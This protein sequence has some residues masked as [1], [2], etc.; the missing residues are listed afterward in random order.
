MMSPNDP[1]CSDGTTPHTSVACEAPRIDLHKQVVLPII[2]GPNSPLWMLTQEPELNG[3]VLNLCQQL[4]EIRKSPNTPKIIEFSRSQVLAARAAFAAMILRGERKLHRLCDL[5]C[6][7]LFSAYQMQSVVFGQIDATGERFVLTQSLQR[8]ELDAISDLDLGTRQ[9]RRIA[10]NTPNGTNSGASLVA[11]V[12]E[13]QPTEA[14]PWKI[15]RLI[16][17]IKAEEEIW[18][19]VADEIFDLDSLVRRDKQISHL[20]LFIKDVFGLKLIVERDSD[21][22]PLHEKLQNLGW[23]NEEGSEV[24][25]L[26][27]IEVKNYMSEE[28]RKSSGW[29]AL[30]S[31]VLWSDKT[32]E[33]QIQPLKRFYN[34]REYLT[35][36]S[37]Q[38]FK[39]RREA[40]RNRIVAEIPLYGFCRDLLRWLFVDD[41]ATP[42][43]QHPGLTILVRR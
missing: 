22:Y 31:V 37:H 40:L 33:I 8:D 14:N 9:L 42:P 41:S 28:N 32:F 39:A 13:Y 27:F 29:E 12:V 20:S 7:D 23:S 30:K 25:Y 2:S 4:D 21:V 5:L 26:N 10:F 11:N 3:F 17:R 38:G 35:R 43:P 15:H 1:T 24:D 19:K 18:N 16:S 34:E 6:Q 36:E